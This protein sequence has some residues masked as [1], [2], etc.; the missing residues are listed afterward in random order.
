MAAFCSIFLYIGSEMQF[1][2]VINEEQALYLWAL[3]FSVVFLVLSFSIVLFLQA[4]SALL[5]PCLQCVHSAA[6]VAKD[7]RAFS[8]GQRSSH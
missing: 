7:G 3:L 2:V 6:T 4:S 5:Y 8:N 1:N